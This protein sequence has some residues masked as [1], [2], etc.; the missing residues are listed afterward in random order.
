MDSNLVVIFMSENNQ[1]DELENNQE[2]H[3]RTR[4]F[5]KEDFSRKEPVIEEIE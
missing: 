1:T 3:I 2:P 5:F 4:V